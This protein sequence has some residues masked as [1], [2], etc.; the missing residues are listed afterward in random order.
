MSSK[1]KALFIFVAIIAV[2]SI[3]ITGTFIIK[4]SYEENNDKSLEELVK[5]MQCEVTESHLEEASIAVNDASLY[6]ELPDIEKY[7][8][9]VEGKGDIDLEIMSSPE[10]AESGMNGW[11]IDT[12]ES[13]NK[14][15]YKT[16]DGKTVSISVRDVSSG[17]AAD[18]II[19][20][21]HVSE[22]YAPSNVLWGYYAESQNAKLELEAESLVGNTAG[23]LVKKDSG[24]KTFEDVYNAVVEGKTSIAYTNPQASTA[25]MNLLV[26]IL[27]NYGEEGFAKFQANVPYVAYNTVQLAASVKTGS[28][29]IM[30]SER[31]TYENDSSLQKEYDFIPYGIRHD[32]PL[33]SCNY[34]SMSEAEKEA[35]KIFVDFAKGPDAQNLATRYGFNKDNEYKSS[36]EATGSDVKD[37]LKI[38][39]SKKDSGKDI[40][41]VFVADCSGSMNG[42]AILQ[43]KQSLENGMQ[44]INEDAYIGLVSYSSDVQIDLPLGKFEM[45]Q[46][47]YF[48]NAINKLTAS[49]NTSTYEALCIALQMIEKEKKN[50]DNPK[51][52]VFVLSDGEANGWY[53]INTIREA[54]KD[55]K[56]PVY[57]IAYTSAADLDELKELSIINEATCINADSDDV[58]YKIKSLFN[59]SL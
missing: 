54:V 18:Y 43:L 29:D 27:K 8:L 6:D 34:S 53:K 12:A 35:V 16:S 28:L 41:A 45:K 5:G 7:P 23:F 4:K 57:T 32:N 49:G 26:N 17:L 31:Q 9:S 24:Y 42:D 39:K 37:A 55:T 14:A 36:Y 2:F 38:Y 1:N 46:K 52:M 40:I 10:K 58:V 44:Y 13:F 3:A 48:Q 20:K 56:V 11:L 25:G 15:K 19:S 50:H 21:K 30:V 51:C 33:Y 47:R 59:A 22:L